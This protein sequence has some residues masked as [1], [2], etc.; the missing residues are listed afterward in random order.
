MQ[1][2][3]VP[4]ALILFTP[5]LMISDQIYVLGDTGGQFKGNNINLTIL[6]FPLDTS[7]TNN[8]TFYFT[9]NSDQSAFLGSSITPNKI[10]HLDYLVIIS[11]GGKEIFHQQMHTHSGNLTLEFTG[12]SGTIGITGG[13]SDPNNTTT[14]PYYVS[15]SVFTGTGN[16]EISASIVGVEFNPLPSPLGHK[17]TLQAVPEFDSMATIILAILI[18]GILVITSRARFGTL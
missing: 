3:A 17:F 9:P 16:Y 14:G 12:G 1:G 7:K 8:I 10:D 2:H 13:Q 11:Q 6:P 5:F 15:G 4:L 18:L